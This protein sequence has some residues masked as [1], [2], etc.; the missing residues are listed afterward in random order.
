MEAAP[1]CDGANGQDPAFDQALEALL[2][3][4]AP[5]GGVRDSFDLWEELALVDRAIARIAEAV[6]VRG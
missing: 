6:G 1:G 4:A 3:A 5:A 2:A